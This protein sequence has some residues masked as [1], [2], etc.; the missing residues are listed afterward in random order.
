MADRAIARRYARAFIDV[1]AEQGSIDT[2]GSDLHRVLDASR[3]GASALFRTLSNPV[4]T[5]QER[6]AALDAILPRLSVHPLVRN[7]LHLLIDNGRFAALADIAEIYGELADERANRARV[8]VETA[9][10]M[11]PQLEA[12]VRAALERVT[13]KQVVLET[14]VNPE[15]I[16]GV[17]AYVGG[18]VYDA[19]VRAR[20][21]DIKQRLISAQLPAEA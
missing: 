19:S 10:P 6:K 21:Q 7:L 15:L 2:F 12:E 1:A 18:K 3:S 17:V 13:G 4:F 5:K 16:G 20:L 8:L 14:R 11:T 9:E